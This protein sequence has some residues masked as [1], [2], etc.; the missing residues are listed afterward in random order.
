VI[1]ARAVL[2]QPQSISN[3]D[4]AITTLA[5]FVESSSLARKLSPTLAFRAGQKLSRDAFEA[6]DVRSAVDLCLE[7]RTA[8]DASWRCAPRLG[9][10]PTIRNARSTGG[11]V[12]NC[13]QAGPIA[14]RDAATIQEVRFAPAPY[15]LTRAITCSAV[16]DPARA[17]TFQSGCGGC[18]RGNRNRC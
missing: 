2:G 10:N 11:P 9:T 14:C 5:C 4:I 3:F 18:C 7:A 12:A 1:A 16:L 13:D 17:I 8:T 15:A 6:L